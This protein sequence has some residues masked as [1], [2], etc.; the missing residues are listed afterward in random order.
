MQSSTKV[1]FSWK[2]IILLLYQMVILLREKIN[3]P[4]VTKQSLS[5][6][7][8]HPPYKTKPNGHIYGLTKITHSYKFVNGLVR[9]TSN[10]G[11]LRSW[12]VHGSAQST[13][14]GSRWSQ[15]KKIELVPSTPSW[16]RPPRD[17]LRSGQFYFNELEKIII[18][19]NFLIIIFN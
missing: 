13:Y 1:L 16:A 4:Q 6:K 11:G 3:V 18:Y 8:S 15:F 19:H 7:S 12:I 17:I 5:S 14:A 2:K 9:S 10:S